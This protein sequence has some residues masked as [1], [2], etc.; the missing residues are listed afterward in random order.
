MP[1]PTGGAGFR[2]G[3]W[4]TLAVAAILLA[5]AGVWRDEGPSLG[6]RLML[7]LFGSL[8]KLFVFR[9]KLEQHALA[10]D[11]VHFFRK[12]AHLFGAF[13]PIVWIVDDSALGHQAAMLAFPHAA[14]NGS[15][16]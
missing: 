6:F 3:E 2:I 15:N 8:G 1:S 11:A 5:C 10:L 14:A 12:G 9:R 4:S 16:T 7:A 13:A